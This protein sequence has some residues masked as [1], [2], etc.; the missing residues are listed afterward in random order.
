MR[1]KNIEAKLPA[2]KFM[3]VQRSFIVNLDKI[4]TVEK[5]RIF[6]EQ[7]KFIPIGE[8]YKEN[9]QQYLGRNFIK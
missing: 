5:N 9:F 6:I 4:Q 3:R 2:D 8:Q 7:K 1:L